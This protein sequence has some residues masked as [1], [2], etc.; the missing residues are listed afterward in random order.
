MHRIRIEVSYDGTD[1]FGWQRLGDQEP[2]IQGAL[3]ESVFGLTG[4]RVA[5]I[6]SGRTDSGVHAIAQTAHF[7]LKRLGKWKDLVYALNS[8]LPHSIRVQKAWIAPQDFH[9]QRSAIWKTYRYRILNRPRPSALNHR[10]SWWVRLPLDLDFLNQTAG[11]LVGSHDFA[12]FQS[13]GGSVQSTHRTLFEAQ[14]EHPKR[15]LFTFTVTGSG[16]LK[17]MVR[18]LVGTQLQLWKYRRP[19]HEIESILTAQ[20]RKKAGLTAPPQGLFLVRV[21]Y[22]E[23]LDNRCCPL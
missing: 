10:Y 12:S 19:A 14:W 15:D 23:D 13:A 21:A 11:L 17:Q 4:E 7:N 1:F 6:G 3:E 20:D 9:A 5:V 22:P 18:N 16:F 8:R 2:T